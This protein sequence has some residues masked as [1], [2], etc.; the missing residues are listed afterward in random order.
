[1][2]TIR[3]LL[4]RQLVRNARAVDIRSTTNKRGGLVFQLEQHKNMILVVYATTF[5]WVLSVSTVPWA[6]PV[7]HTNWLSGGWGHEWEQNSD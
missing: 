2:T 7:S 6:F 1:V 5:L 3:G 4:E